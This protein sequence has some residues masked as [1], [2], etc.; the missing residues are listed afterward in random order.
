MN[1]YAL[2]SSLALGMTDKSVGWGLWESGGEAAWFSKPFHSPQKD[3]HSERSE[4]S[5]VSANKN[6]KSLIFF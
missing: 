2:D 3:C 4:K 6:Q 5:V 1:K